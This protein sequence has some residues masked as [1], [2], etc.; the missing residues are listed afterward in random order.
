MFRACL[1]GLSQTQ[2]FKAIN[3]RA[4]DDLVKAHKIVYSIGGTA[5]HIF[6]NSYPEVETRP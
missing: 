1:C 5:H 3:E 6:G 4:A 2:R